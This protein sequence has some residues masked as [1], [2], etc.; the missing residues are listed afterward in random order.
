MSCML[1]SPINYISRWLLLPWVLP[2][3]ITH[4]LDMIRDVCVLRGRQEGS[5]PCL[6][7][8]LMKQAVARFAWW[9]VIICRSSHWIYCCQ[10]TN[11]HIYYCCLNCVW[12]QD[13]NKRHDGEMYANMSCQHVMPPWGFAHDNWPIYNLLLSGKSHYYVLALCCVFKSRQN[14]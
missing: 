3:Y 8:A 13:L 10:C 4:F 2:R 11:Q 7:A 1:Y 12:R 9:T 5:L 14:D 6:S